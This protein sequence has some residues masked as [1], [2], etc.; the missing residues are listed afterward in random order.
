VDTD[1]TGGFGNLEFVPATRLAYN[2]NDTWAV[3]AEEYSDFGPLRRF[4]P[5]SEQF[6]EVWAVMDHNSKIVNIEA[7]VGVGVTGGADRLT[8][9]LMVSRDLNS[10]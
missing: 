5:L 3:A 2:F 9:K 7:G 4:D 8:L 6:H 10:K 1:Y